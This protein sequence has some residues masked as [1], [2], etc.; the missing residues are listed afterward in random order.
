MKTTKAMFIS[1]V[2]PAVVVLSASLAAQAGTAVKITGQI[3][4]AGGKPVAGARI[5]ESWS[6]AEGKPLETD[7]PAITDAAGKFSVEMEFYQRDRALLAFDGTGKLG[8]VAIVSHK[9]PEKPLRIQLSPLSELR[10][11]YGSEEPAHPIS[12]SFLTLLLT[13]GTI[14]LVW[15]RSRASAYSIK[16]P[17]GR[18]TIRGEGGGDWYKTDMREAKLEPGKP[19]DVGEIKLP[20]STIARLYGQRAPAWHFADVR[21]VPRDVQ[22]AS[23]KGKWVVLEF[24]GYWCGPCVGRGLPGWMDFVDDH[25]ADRDKFAILAIHERKITDF[26]T[27]DEKLKP[28]IRRTWRGRPLPFP[29]AIDATGAMTKDYGITGFPTAVLIDPAGRVV[30]FGRKPTEFG[31]AICEEFLA[32]KLTPLPLEKRMARS[33]DRSQAL[34]VND[35]PLNELMEFYSRVGRLKIRLDPKELKAAGIDAAVQ[36]PLK[37]GGR[38][39]LRAWLNLTLDTFDLTYVADGA[40]LR[41]VRRTVANAGL[42]QPSARSSAENALVATALERKVTF[43]FHDES[44]KQ[45]CAKLESLTDE[46][47]L[48]DPRSRRTGAINPEATMSGSATDEPLSSALTRLLAPLKMTYVIRDGAVLLSAAH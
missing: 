35:E 14:P 41:I 11:R 22:P 42:S 20:L 1:A 33:L 30:D 45:V 47:F 6:T 32:S 29:I 27:L 8:A 9:T 44:W 31:S 40:G 13:D 46:T 43:H 19:L 16:L 4:D 18:Y 23:F 5:S 48:L 34:G 7:H 39:T 24:W 37:V 12:E 25:A 10:F 28:I 26:Q 38:L 15:G 3:V 36:V 17:A 21:G 2:V